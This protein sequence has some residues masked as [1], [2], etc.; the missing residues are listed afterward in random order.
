MHYLMIGSLA[1]K[2]DRSAPEIDF[3]LDMTPPLSL[4][5]TRTH[6]RVPTHRARALATA[7]AVGS[8]ETEKPGETNYQ[9]TEC[10]RELNLDENT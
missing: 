2:A 6:R 1:T 8:Y 9:F 3:C 10:L 4:Y 7:R 5:L